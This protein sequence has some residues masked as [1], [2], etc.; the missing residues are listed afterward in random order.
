MIHRLHGRMT[1]LLALTTTRRCLVF[2]V[3]AIVF[4]ETYVHIFL[5]RIDVRQNILNDPLLDGP[6]EEIQ[7]ANCGLLNR[8]LAANLEADSLAA[9]KRIKQTLGIR[10]E[11]AFVMEMHHELSVLVEITDIEFLGIVRDEPIYQS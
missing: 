9:T 7:L 6:A 1:H 10:L 2:G 8:R 5:D 4:P 11:F 3:L